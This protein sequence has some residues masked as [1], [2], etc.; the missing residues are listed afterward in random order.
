MSAPEISDELCPKCKVNY[1]KA[2]HAH[3]PGRVCY[4]CKYNLAHVTK[5][6]YRRRRR[7]QA[8]KRW[9]ERNPNKE[10]PI[11]LQNYAKTLNA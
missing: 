9:Y 4:E 5:D 10:L 1:I 8:L 2:K 11:Q 3:K 6:A 7:R